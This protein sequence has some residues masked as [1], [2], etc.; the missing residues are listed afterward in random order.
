MTNAKKEMEKVSK[1]LDAYEAEVKSLTHDQL[2]KAP[3][4]EV[5]P[6]TKISQK[7][8]SKK[9][10]I[11]LKP[12]KTI[13][14]RDKFNEDYREQWNYAKE[15]VHFISENYECIGDT[16]EMWTK[17]FA[18]VPAEFWQVPANKPVWGPRYLAEQITRCQYHRLVSV[19]KPQTQD[20]KGNIYTG[21]MIAD[22][23]INRLNAFPVKEQKSIFMGASS[24]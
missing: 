10:E 12:F 16:I 13:G 15:Y 22:K 8:L 21:G 3:V 2:S 4:L 14:G 19:D 6:Q 5:E 17:P 9:S 23:T 7:E 18:G 20:E 24:F 11:Y 1:Q